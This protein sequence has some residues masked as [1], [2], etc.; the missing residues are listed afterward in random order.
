MII[1]RAPLEGAAIIHAEL[2][3]DHRGTF[4][5]FFC[6]RELKEILGERRIVNV[7]FSRTRQKGAIRGL[8]FQYP[9][10]EEMKLIRCIRGAVLDVIVDIRKN[11]PTFLQWFGIELSAEN[12]LMLC[13]PEGF[14]HGFQVLEDE[15]EMIYL[16]TELYYPEYEGG[17]RHSDPD[18][19][20]TWPLKPTDISM[21]DREHGLVREGFSGVV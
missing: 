1:E 5:R 19:H 20:I 12:M 11:S 9:P 14:A 17:L 4:S 6:E 2:F 15:S 16:T 13:V 7:N 21:K 18:L 10:K 3:S 8:H